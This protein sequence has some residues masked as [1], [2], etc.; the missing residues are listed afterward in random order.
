MEIK[1][2]MLLS[3]YMY[4]LPIHILQYLCDNTKQV[5]LCPMIYIGI[6]LYL[7]SFAGKPKKIALI[8]ASSMNV[9]NKSRINILFIQKSI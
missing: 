3:W 1:I 2:K 4:V 5:P 7:E 9:F 6:K 8:C